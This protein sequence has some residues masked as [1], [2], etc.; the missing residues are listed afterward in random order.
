M[1]KKVLDKGKPDDAM[2]AFK[3][4]KVITAFLF[5]PLSC[6]TAEFCKTP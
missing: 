5:L 1:H 3:N 6:L 2:P 4:R